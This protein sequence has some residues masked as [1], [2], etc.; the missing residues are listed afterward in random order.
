M[1]ETGLD[2]PRDLHTV[3]RQIQDIK[4]TGTQAGRK[5]IGVQ[6]GIDIENLDAVLDTLPLFDMTQ[7]LPSD[8]LHHFTLG[9]GKKSLV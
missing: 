6:F 2:I 8:I 7:D 4:N 3:R 1:S 5:R 9:W